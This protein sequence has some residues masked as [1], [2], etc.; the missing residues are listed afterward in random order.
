[1]SIEQER[2]AAAIAALESQRTLLGDAVV[3]AALGP[4]REKLAALSAPPGGADPDLRQVTILFLDVV[5][6]T[7]LSTRLD[8]E[9][10][11]AVMDGALARFTKIVQA[12]GGKVLQYAGDNLLAVF[13][14]ELSREDDAER[15]VRCGLALLDEARVH[16][17]AVRRAHAHDGFD[18]RVGLHTGGV[19]LGAADGVDGAGSIRGRAVNVAARM[20]QL[21]P[22]GQLRISQ[23]THALVRGLFHADRQAPVPVKGVDEPMVTYLVRAAAAAGAPARG[24]EGVDT[25]MVG[26]DAEMA[27][28]Q[29]AFARLASQR[30]LQRI[31]IVGDAGL[32][33]S[34]LLKEFNAWLRDGAEPVV[35]LQVRATPATQSRPYGLLRELLA[36]WLG[37]ADDADAAVARERFELGMVPLLREADAADEGGS[38]ARAQAHALGHLIGLDYAASRTCKASSTM[39][40]RFASAAFM[41]GCGRCAASARAMARRCCC[42]ATTCTGPTR[43]RSISSTSWHLKAATCRSRSSA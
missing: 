23:A 30:R 28:L 26:R 32:G 8:P 2:L 35:Q 9:D 10:V 41:R 33:K 31:H 42:S 15:A 27:A 36:S 4:L 12:H 22:P 7:R 13:G 24:V 16:Q 25:R 29:Q 21:A 1:M 37:V 5:G 20:E 17:A 19:L 43:V 3:D 40:G 18:V 11:N 14:A 38:L 6:S 34:R 39:G